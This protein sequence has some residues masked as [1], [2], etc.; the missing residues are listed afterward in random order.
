MNRRPA[1]VVLT[2]V[3]ALIIAA[4]P[5]SAYW[6]TNGIAACAAFLGQEVPQLVSDGAGGTIVTWRDERGGSYDIY[7]Q[8]INAA[9]VPVWASDG[10]AICTDINWQNNPAI[11]SDGA[12][13]A[14][15]AW[16]DNRGG[17][18][19]I[20]AQRVSASG[21]I[22]WM[23]DGQVICSADGDQSLPQIETDAAGGAIIAWLDNRSMSETDIYAQ[24]INAAGAVQWTWD[25]VAVCTASNG[26]YDQKLI[27]DGAG[28]AIISWD[29]FRGGSNF[30][31]YAQRMNGSGTPLWTANGVAICARAGTQMF[32]ALATDGAG[33]AIVAWF[34]SRLGYYDIY[35]Q[36]VNASGAVQ[37][38]VNGIAVCNAAMDQTYISAVSDD[39]G[40][41][42]LTWMDARSG[43]GFDVYAQRLNPA[44]VA[45][46]T[47]NGV[48]LSTASLD[49]FNVR[50]VK[51]GSGGVIVAWSDL[52]NGGYDVYA[53]CVSASGAV[54]WTAD[55][56]PVC[57]SV[58]EQDQVR[59][60]SDGAGGAIAAWRDSRTGSADIYCQS[61]DR[62]GRTGF[63][64]PDIYAVRDIPGDQGGAIYLSWY[65]AR[66]D[67][68]RTAD[69]NYYTIWR[70]IDPLA[71][72]LAIEKGARFLEALADLDPVCGLPVVR[73]ERI[74][75]LEYFWEL[76]ESQ[77]AYYRAAYGK[78][79]ATLFD[80]TGV[81]DEYHYFQVVAHTSDPFV[82][83]E[84]EVGS[85]RSVDNLVPAAPLGLEGEQQYL[86]V[87]LELQWL[88]NDESDLAGYAIY[89]GTSEDFV[90]DPASL[91][92]T[93]CDTF[94]VDGTW[95]W[96]GGYYYKVAAVDIHE[97]E[98]GYALL[99]PGL[100]TGSDDPVMPAAVYLEQNVPNPFNPST[101]IGFGLAAPAKVRLRVYDAAGRLVRELAN[102][103]MPAGRHVE[104]WDGRNEDGVA[105]ASGV[106]FYRLESGSFTETRKMVLLK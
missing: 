42:I 29:D 28:G 81:S 9:G 43:A 61:V 6:T 13:G 66:P 4:A 70:A 27:P 17:Y 87:G 77:G 57:T 47:A 100:I 83:W 88:A 73:L 90:P 105:A 49:Q 94:Y 95:S 38:T 75:T 2:A 106:Y 85:G 34:D 51:D 32:P 24:R 30:D 40:G 55:G 59:F 63:L 3:I 52:R 84:S 37:W 58:G 50:P 23:E 8:H 26:Q 99:S 18:Y 93:T 71:A 25:G 48:A 82:F 7:A 76:I 35:A 16:Q 31:I 22:L 67:A 79:V 96:E 104:E 64:A 98:S 65:A 20:Y 11:V 72:S 62:E 74:G 15:I 91:V 68:F 46:W 21:A 103:I 12:G 80:S 86:P 39:A 1:L 5:A 101:R 44:G 69:V 56:A 33:G 54:Q 36:S 53:Q 41:A 78:P 92:A 45:Q 60:V 97:N 89:R 19:D 102:G 10:V 14:I